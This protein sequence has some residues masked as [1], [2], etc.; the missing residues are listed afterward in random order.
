VADLLVGKQFYWQDSLLS[1]LKHV[2]SSKNIIVLIKQQ[3]DE[4]LKLGNF[5]KQTYRI[6]ETCHF[7][8]LVICLS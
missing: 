4:T 6:E 1:A 8:P 2:E 5:I 7:K 3:R